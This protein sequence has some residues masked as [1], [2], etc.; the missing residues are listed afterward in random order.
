MHPNKGFTLTEILIVIV[1]I[2]LIL[3]FASLAFGDFGKSKRLL[4]AVEHLQ[5]TLEL[6]QQ[7]AILNTSTYG[8]QI[9]N[10]S[11]QILKFNNQSQWVPASVKGVFKTYYFP[12]DTLVT[13]QSALSPSSSAPEIILSPTGQMTPFTLT[14]GTPQEKEVALLIGQVNGDLQVTKVGK[15]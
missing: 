2:G 10:N 6:A 7:Q 9:N 11:Y 14:F 15:K 1:I 5:N 3:G 12:S 8:L 4:F 13:L